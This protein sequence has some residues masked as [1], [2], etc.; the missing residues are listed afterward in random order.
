MEKMDKL[1]NYLQEIADNCYIS[2]LM[3]WEMDIVAP[4][5]SIDYIINVKTKVETKTFELALS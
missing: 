4:K 1:L 5:K 2:S 3:H